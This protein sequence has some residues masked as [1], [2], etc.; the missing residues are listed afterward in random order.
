MRLQ[1]KTIKVCVNI[2]TK[3]DFLLKF[4]NIKIKITKPKI[5]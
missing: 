5:D 3:I 2:L 1:N 4:L